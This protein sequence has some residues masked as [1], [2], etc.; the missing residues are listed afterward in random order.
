MGIHV[1]PN[2]AVEEI[3][4][5][6]VVHAAA[7]QRWDDNIIIMGDLNADCSYVANYRWD[8]IPLRTDQKYYWPI[9][10]DADTTVATSACAYDRYDVTIENSAT[11]RKMTRCW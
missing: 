6:T 2:D 1:S 9:A 8:S 10:D 3:G 11:S 5:L 7:V 4:N